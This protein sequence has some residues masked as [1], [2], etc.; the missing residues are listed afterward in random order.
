MKKRDYLQ[1]SL[2][3][4]PPLLVFLSELSAFSDGA[5]APIEFPT[6]PAVAVERALKAAGLSVKDI[7]LWEINEAFAVVVLANA[8]IMG[9]DVSKI[10]VNGG[11]V[12]LGHP[13]G[14]VLSRK[15][16]P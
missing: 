16:D 9:V 7:D 12:S 11:A 1:F 14:Y 10:N 5:K 13:I 15:R 6:A 4:F 3:H 8:Q 2:H